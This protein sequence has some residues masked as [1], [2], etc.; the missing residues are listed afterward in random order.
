LKSS[1]ASPWPGRKKEEKERNMPTNTLRQYTALCV[2]FFPL[3]AFPAFACE[4]PVFERAIDLVELSSE[5]L[6]IAWKPVPDASYYELKYSVKV[7][8]GRTLFQRERRIEQAAYQFST[9]EFPSIERLQLLVEVTAQCN[10]DQSEPAFTQL[11]I[12]GSTTACAFGKELPTIKNGELHLPS[13][14]EAQGYILCTQHADKP[15][16]CRE[17]NHISHRVAAPEG[18]GMTITPLCGKLPGKPIY[19]ASPSQS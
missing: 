4:K 1:F 5:G 3:L 9:A 14:K 10:T 18:T 19:V 11:S 16:T 8:E 2:N 13:L 15:S 12:I 6:P 17:V 7:P